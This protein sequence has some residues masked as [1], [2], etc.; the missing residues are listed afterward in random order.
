MFESNIP[1]LRERL[2]KISSEIDLH[3][4][5]LKDLRREK[6]LVSRRLNQASDPMARL[7]LE[8]SSEILLLESLPPF[9]VTQP[10]LARVGRLILLKICTAWTSIALS[11]PSLW[12]TI[13]VDLSNPRRVTNSCR[14]GSSVREIVPCLSRFMEISVLTPFLPSFGGMRSASKSS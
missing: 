2:E 14:L 11:I 10:R 12:S 7:P 4:K 1:A 3:E 9:E 6:I 5:L 13:P 8:I